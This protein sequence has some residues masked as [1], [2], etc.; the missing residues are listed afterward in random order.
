MT[1]D[2]EIRELLAPSKLRITAQR[3]G[4]ARLLFSGPHRHVV[5]SELHFE[6]CQAGMSISLATVYNTL[7]Q[8]IRAGLLREVSVRATGTYYDTNVEPHCHTYDPCT[9]TLRDLK[10]PEVQL[11]DGIQAEHVAGVDLLFYLRPNS[12]NPASV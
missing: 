10:M 1:T 7:S 4:L 3:V 2:D 8:F 9:G 6:A 5:A 12:E 11:P